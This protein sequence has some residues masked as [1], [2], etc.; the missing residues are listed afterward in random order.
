[1]LFVSSLYVKDENIEIVELGT[2]CPGMHDFLPAFSIQEQKGGKR[3]RDNYAR[4]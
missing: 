3:L 4:N 1:M 2:L